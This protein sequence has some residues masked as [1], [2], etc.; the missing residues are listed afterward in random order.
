MALPAT[1]KVL[2]L[3]LGNGMII[4]T[5]GSLE[6]LLRFS[7]VGNSHSHGEVM[8]DAIGRAGRAIVNVVESFLPVHASFEHQ[9]KSMK[10]TRKRENQFALNTFLRTAKALVVKM[11]FQAAFIFSLVGWLLG[12]MPNIYNKLYKH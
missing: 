4:D 8:G 2:G 6:M 5:E 12:H 10:T 1:M 3:G 9:T 7:R 11:G